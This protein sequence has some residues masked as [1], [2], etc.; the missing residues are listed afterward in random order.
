MFIP[1]VIGC[2]D[3]EQ[4][5]VVKGCTIGELMLRNRGGVF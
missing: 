4:R 5:G 3:M 2:K 1:E